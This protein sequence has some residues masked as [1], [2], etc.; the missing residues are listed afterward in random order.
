MAVLQSS[1]LAKTIQDPVVSTLMLDNSRV[2]ARDTRGL[3]NAQHIDKLDEKLR[4][5]LVVPGGE[6]TVYRHAYLDVEHDGYDGL[7]QE[8]PPK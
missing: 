5:K 8:D 1:S 2:L 4:L 7:G 3:Y 6:G